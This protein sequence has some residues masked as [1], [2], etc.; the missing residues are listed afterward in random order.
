[1]QA[2]QTLSNSLVPRL[3]PGLD[4]RKLPIGPEEAFVL[5]RVDG[6]TTARD[7]GYAT[8]L[9]EDQVTRHLQRLHS[10]GAV[11]FSEPPPPPASICPEAKR[12]Q[13]SR[14]GL[15]SGSV[16][17]R[18][19]PE[20]D[21][22]PPDVR[23]APQASSAAPSSRSDRIR[24]TPP[25]GTRSAQLYPAQ[26]LD[27]AV[28][29]DRNRKQEI[30]DLYYRLDV[31]DHYALLAISPNADRRQV[32]TA[33]YEKVK[34][35]HPDRYF[36]KE[37]GPFRAKLEQCFARLTEA[38]DTL[39]NA[40]S[41]EEYD[42]YLAS[43]KQTIELERA[44]SEPVTTSDFDRLEE[45]LRMSLQATASMP[46]SA[47]SEP[48]A[49]S[50][51]VPEPVIDVIESEPPNS[52]SRMSDE[53]RLRFLAKKLRVSSANLRAVSS[54]ASVPPTPS[55][56]PPSRQQIAEQLRRQLGGT[57]RQI[58][59]HLA[60]ADTAM[61]TNQPIAAVNALRLA[62]SLA[63]EDPK[64]SERLS[65]AQSLAAHTLADTYLHQAEYEEKSGRFDAAARSYDRAAQGKPS[66]DTW[67]AAA[68][69]AFQAGSDMRAAAD[70][71][72][73]A[74]ALDPERPTGHLLLGQIFLAARMRSSAITELERARRLDPN[75]VTV[76]SLLKRIA[77]KEI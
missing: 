45:Q 62:Q 23:S 6:Q 36:G 69:C 57:R 13:R 17:D 46:P 19:M 37:L 60:A 4:I 43:Q 52:P 44:F 27:A 16:V 55:A 34:I 30:L 1:M 70:Y 49:I 5:S 67:E 29:L 31:L 11:Q 8:S 68:R 65:Q 42:A 41:R 21:R 76:L 50:R 18:P 47:S 54:P 74:L 3:V 32:K 40:S 24:P 12:T 22:T 10:L 66:P 48:R 39:A 64:I 63:P 51:P 35:F 2:L 53:E 75:N 72:R 28:D 26:E 25:N 73:K 9:T 20:V 33:Y 61:T 59:V 15:T 71:A 7:I 38:H 77:D 58:E 56:P 14:T